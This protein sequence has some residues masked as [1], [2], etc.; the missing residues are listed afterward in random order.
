MDETMVTYACIGLFAVVL[1]ANYA[2][3]R[4]RGRKGAPSEEERSIRE[5]EVLLGLGG[6]R[7]DGIMR[8]LGLTPYAMLWNLRP[9]KDEMEKARGRRGRQR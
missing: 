4:L 5:A 7:S 6:S 8:A 3:W 1:V 2:W 9:T